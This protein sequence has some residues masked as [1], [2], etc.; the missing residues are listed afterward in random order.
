M[1]SKQKRKRQKK[2]L[3]LTPEQV[4]EGER[5]AKRL[6]REVRPFVKPDVKRAG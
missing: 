5:V 1:T 6:L 2:P 4:K 3:H